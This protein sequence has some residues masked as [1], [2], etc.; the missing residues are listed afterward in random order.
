MKLSPKERLFAALNFDEVDMNPCYVLDG[1]SWVIKEE[2]INYETQY[3]LDDCG[4]KMI[5]DHFQEMQSDVITSGTSA[6]MAWATAFGSEA[7]LKEIGTTISTL[8]AVKKYDE[9]PL[10]LTEDQLRDKLLSNPIV[11]AMGKQNKLV[12]KLVG[13]EKAIVTFVT[14]PFTAASTLLGAAPFMK[15]WAKK[16]PGV[17]ELFNFASRVIA[18]LADYYTECGADII[19]TADPVASGDM[20]SLDTYKEFAV[21]AYK[22][23]LELRHLDTPLFMHICGNAGERVEEVAN[24]GVKTFSVDSMVD[25]GD[26]LKRAD[27]KICMMGSLSPAD[28]MLLGNPDAVYAEA[29]RLLNL[30]RENGGGFLLST[31]CDLPAGSPLAN[32]LAMRKAVEDFA[33]QK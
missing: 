15:M 4:A 30:G 26:M 21:P 8:P 18:I 31:G 11:Q 29:T 3:A 23:F 9:L 6:W 28:K 13:D 27:H 19:A 5:Y 10:D 14:A 33:A 20:I 22:K 17:D 1:S 24:L 16:K 2:G 25:M 12:K 32:I 7:N